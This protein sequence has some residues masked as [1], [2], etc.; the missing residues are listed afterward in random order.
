MS[1]VWIYTSKCVRFCATPRRLEKSRWI[2]RLA[3]ILS[4]SDSLRGFFHPQVPV[5]NLVPIPVAAA[6]FNEEFL[7]MKPPK[8]WI[9]DGIDD[10][11]FPEVTV[12]A[13]HEGQVERAALFRNV[14][15][16]LSGRE[17]EFAFIS[18]TRQ[19]RGETKYDP[20]MILIRY[21]AVSGKCCF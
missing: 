5:E 21:R 10:S 19:R 12:V 3:K 17:V 7:T 14:L 9:P 8:G 20:G 13:A 16:R 15:Q 18:K 11:Y 6:Y 4:S 2:L 1:C